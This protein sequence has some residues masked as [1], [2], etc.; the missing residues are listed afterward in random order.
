MWADNTPKYD[1]SAMT[2]SFSSFLFNDEK[3]YSLPSGIISIKFD[4]FHENKKKLF[5]VVDANVSNVF[6]YSSLIYELYR[7]TWVDFRDEE[8]NEPG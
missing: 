1:S 4:E 3:I 5:A 8:K 2:C 7:S 6:V